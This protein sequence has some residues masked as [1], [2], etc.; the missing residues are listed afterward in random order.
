MTTYWTSCN[1]GGFTECAYSG[2]VITTIPGQPPLYICSW[3]FEG[4]VKVVTCPEC[5]ATPDT[6]EY[7]EVEGTSSWGCKCNG[8]LCTLDD[9][10][11]PTLPTGITELTLQE[12]FSKIRIDASNPID[13]ELDVSVLYTC[14]G[15]DCIDPSTLISYSG[16]QRTTIKTIKIVVCGLE[17]IV[18]DRKN[19]IFDL[20]A[21]DEC[22]T[23]DCTINI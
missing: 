21:D 1:V 16:V 20:G 4:G 22:N 3:G 13:A 5:C 17:D 15:S 12:T 19:P 8:K 2:T 9:V 14:T 10:I 18:L 23:I 7:E 11:Y 6:Y